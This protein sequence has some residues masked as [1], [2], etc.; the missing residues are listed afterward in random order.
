MEKIAPIAAIWI[1]TLVVSWMIGNYTGFVEGVERM[2]SAFHESAIE[3]GYGQ[4]CQDTGHWKWKGEC[5]PTTPTREKE[6]R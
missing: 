1:V 2:R 6:D 3:R 5:T 4:Y